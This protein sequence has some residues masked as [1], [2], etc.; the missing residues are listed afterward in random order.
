V[1]YSDL[2]IVTCSCPSLQRGW[3][4]CVCKLWPMKRYWEL[5]WIWIPCPNIW[6]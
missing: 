2:I 5:F 6:A 4:Q 3:C 1:F